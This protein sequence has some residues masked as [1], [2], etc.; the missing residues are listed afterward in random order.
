MR[1]PYDT[2]RFAEVGDLGQ[3]TSHMDV[4]Q[5]VQRMLSDL[6][7]HPDEWENPALDRFLEALAASLEA[8][9]DAYAN[10]GEQFPKSPTWETPAEALVMASGYE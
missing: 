9:P 10:R 5:I 3:V 6:L 2:G 7:A 4:A 8:L 1:G